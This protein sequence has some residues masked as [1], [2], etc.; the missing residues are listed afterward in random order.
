MNH[1]PGNTDLLRRRKY[2]FIYLGTVDLLAQSKNLGFQCFVSS[3]TARVKT[4]SSQFFGFYSHKN[5]PSFEKAAKIK[6]RPPTIICKSP[7]SHSQVAN[8][9]QLIFSCGEPRLTSF[10]VIVGQFGRHFK[11]LTLPVNCSVI[12]FFSENISS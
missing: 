9:W 2:H 4:F 5:L 8:G 1:E 7:L 3:E 12:V 11:C 10:L 6:V